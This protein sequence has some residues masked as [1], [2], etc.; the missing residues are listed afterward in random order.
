MDT[1]KYIESGVL[2]QYCMGWL[3]EEEEAYL[4]Q[5]AMLYPEIKAELSAIEIAM[6]KMAAANAVEPAPRIKEKIL[7]AIGFDEDKELNI[8]DL[9]VINRSGDP[10]PWLNVF[11]HLIPEF[12][13]RNFSSHVIRNDEQVRQMLVVTKANVP[14]EEHSDLFEGLFILQGRCECTI[15]ENFYVMGAGDFIEIPLYTKHNIK[16]TTPHVTAILQCRFVK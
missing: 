5:M 7:L 11:S 14:E 13:S 4:I 1:G 16:L 15:G 2:E 10:Q 8:N 6:E 12:P 3:D 9:P